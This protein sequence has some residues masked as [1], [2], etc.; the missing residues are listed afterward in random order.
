MAR[1]GVRQLRT[2]AP[3]GEGDRR[4]LAA[5]LDGSRYTLLSSTVAPNHVHTLVRP[6]HAVDLSDILYSWKRFSSG[7]MR[8]LPEVQ[9]SWSGPTRHL[10]QTESFDHIVRSRSAFER[11][12]LYIQNHDRQPKPR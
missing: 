9:S 1:Q 7:Q 8:K 12:D 11:F 2:R 10:W 5:P 3:A 4:D 6:A